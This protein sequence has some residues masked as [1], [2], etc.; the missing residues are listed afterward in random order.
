MFFLRSPVF[1]PQSSLLL[2][3][4]NGKDDEKQQV[5]FYGAITCL[6]L[7]FLDVLKVFRNHSLLI[8]K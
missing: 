4:S 5:T 2:R 8:V 1:R 6:V 7:S 3:Y